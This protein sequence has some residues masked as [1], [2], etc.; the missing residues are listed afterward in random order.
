MSFY[1]WWM[2]EDK[3]CWIRGYTNALY[4]SKMWKRLIVFALHCRS[5]FI[6]LD[7]CKRCLHPPLSLGE[8]MKE[9][10]TLVFNVWC[11]YPGARIRAFFD[12]GDCQDERCPG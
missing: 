2:D 5:T 10:E 6:G 4:G 1:E 8:S 11:G 9:K 12:D 7:G 3:D